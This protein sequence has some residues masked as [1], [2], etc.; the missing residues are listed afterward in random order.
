MTDTITDLLNRYADD[1]SA[2]HTHPAATVRPVRT[3][4]PAPA[5][6]RMAVP[7]LAAAAV[8]GVVA[9]AAL[10]APDGSGPR[11]T[12]GPVAATGAPEP[13][14][15]DDTRPPP[16]VLLPETNLPSDAPVVPPPGRE[17]LVVTLDAPA[18]A[19]V[20]ELTTYTVTL[21]NPSD[22]PVPLR[23]CPAYRFEHG[24]QQST[25]RLPCDRL[26]NSLEPGQQV[27]IR[28]AAQFGFW[29]GPETPRGLPADLAWA[30]AGPP[31]ARAKTVITHPPLPEPLVTAPFA[32]LPAPP[33]EPLPGPEGLRLKAWRNSQ[34]AA[35]IVE[36]P[37]S[38]KA[39]QTLRYTVRLFNN[40]ADTAW[41]LAPCRGF[42][43]WLQRPARPAGEQV[44]W[45]DWSFET[46]EAQSVHSTEHGLNCD[47]LPTEIPPRQS[48]HLQMELPVPAD[49]PTGP[50]SL[51]W[52]VGEL[53]NFGSPQSRYATVEVLH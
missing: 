14:Q 16:P 44:A 24:W 39:G 51:A 12:I 11:T 22:Q 3:M 27:E 34:L 30:I 9:G 7:A 18:E 40:S 28:L 6:R 45:L 53:D 1:M 37:A 10:I 20:E 13:F 26:P 15:P 48:V 5:W 8:V 33:G 36:V 23:P 50:A 41:P 42:T 31:A 29:D 21:S 4:R 52:K 25:G 43:Q 17:R 35:A 49:Y 47:S 19:P 46:G 2:A 32:A 38:V